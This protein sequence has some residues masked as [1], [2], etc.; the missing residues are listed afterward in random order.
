[1][2]K[3]ARSQHQIL[4]WTPRPFQMVAKKHGSLSL[5]VL[6]ACLYPL[7]GSTVSASS[8]STIRPI[9]SRLI[10]HLTSP[11]FLPYKVGRQ[12]YALN[13]SSDR[14]SL[15]HAIRWDI[16][17][18]NLR[19]FRTSPS[20]TRR[21]LSSRLWLDDDEHF[22]TILSNPTQPSHLLSYRSVHGLLSR[23]Q[24]RKFH[25]DCLMCWSLRLFR[26]QHGSSKNEVL[27]L[28]WS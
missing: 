8:R 14:A 24:L 20:T 2:Q 12:R 5:G 16:R 13:L 19:R 15:L 10:L 1:M 9:S 25:C 6:P 17:R 22:N 28:A 23:I 27:L 26:H 3:R 11:G 4:G 18:Q 21:H 7:A